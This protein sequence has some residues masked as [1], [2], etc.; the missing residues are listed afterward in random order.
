MESKQ[1]KVI[2]EVKLKDDLT[3]MLKNKIVNENDPIEFIDIKQYQE[4]QKQVDKLKTDESK[5]KYRI[6]FLKEGID[7]Y[8]PHSKQSVPKNNKSI[9]LNSESSIN[10]NLMDIP[11]HIRTALHSN[12]IENSLYFAKEININHATEL[13]PVLK[14]LEASNVIELSWTDHN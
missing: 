4:L 9:N 5:L 12:N 14:S 11:K 8:Q 3:K 6:K 7:S 1:N 13:V 10:I 2:N